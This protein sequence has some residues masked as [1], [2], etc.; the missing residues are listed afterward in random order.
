[1]LSATSRCLISLANSSPSAQFVADTEKLS[2][3]NK[4]AVLA[5]LTI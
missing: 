2:K 5:V 4:Q 3:D 1:M